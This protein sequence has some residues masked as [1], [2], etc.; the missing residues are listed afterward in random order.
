MTSDWLLIAPSALGLAA[1]W[2]GREDRREGCSP[3]LL[4]L[5]FA[6]WLPLALAVW[7][8]PAGGSWTAAT[9]LRLAMLGLVLAVGFALVGFSRRYLAGEARASYYRRWLL[10][11]LASVSLTVLA[12]HLLLFWIGWAAISL[13]IHRLLLF[14]PDRPRAVLAAHKKFLFARA[15]EAL[16]LF[17]FALLWAAHG[18]VGIEALAAQFA[19]GSALGGPDRLA[20]LLLAA[21]ALIK[22]AQLPLHGWL[23]Q[24][25]ESPTPVSALL[26]AGVINFGGFLLVL[27]A[28]LVLQV[29]EARWLLLLGGGLSMALA[30]LI[31]TTRISV[32]VRLAWSTCAQMGLMLVECALGLLELA[33]LHLFA[34]SA[35]KAYAFLA[36]GEEVLEDLARRVAPAAVPRGLDWLWGAL[37]ALLCTG[38]A[39]HL[40]GPAPWS[41]W[42]LL[43][44]ALAL[45]VAE[46]GGVRLRPAPWG[47]WALAGGL[48]LAYGVG[49]GAAAGL[50]EIPPHWRSAPL[51]AADL[52]VASLIAAL[53]AT[54]WALRYRAHHPWV[55]RL[56]TALFAGLNLD[57]WATR[58]T[59]YLWPVRLPT[60]HSGK[61]HRIRLLQRSSTGD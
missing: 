28:P 56:S 3:V 1:W 15:A 11:T 42:L 34:H 24:V 18:E 21:A 8:R 35:Y 17:A 55:E 31:M 5:L 60:G 25:V 40:W 59:L 38:A 48:V 52:W 10:A 19:A 6:A 37:G 12:D 13:A 14:Y 53:A 49:K 50:V 47:S 29:P 2:A 41:V 26:H 33:L 46:R 16:L 54:A 22:C 27:F 39:A 45:L 51:S 9:P 43:G 61:R 4:A 32:K 44:L 57:E 58:L 30:A 7:V 36:S 20:A 23:I